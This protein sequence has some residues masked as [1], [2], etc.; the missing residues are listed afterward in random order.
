MQVQAKTSEDIRPDR[1]TLFE[2]LLCNSL[3]LI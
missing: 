2:R 1:V 3:L